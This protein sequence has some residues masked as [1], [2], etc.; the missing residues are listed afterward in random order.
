MSDSPQEAIDVAL[1]TLKRREAGEQLQDETV[2]AAHPHLSPYLERELKKLK[3][4]NVAR[5]AATA[6]HATDDVA[7]LRMTAFAAESSDI[8]TT[9][10]IHSTA[11]DE[12]EHGHA[13]ESIERTKL[14]RPSLRPAMAMLRVFHDDG[15]TYQSIPLRGE[16]TVIGRRTGDVLIEHDVLLSTQ[17]AEIVRTEID[18]VWHWHLRDLGSTNGSFVR[19]D[20]AR[21]NDGNDLLMGSN[22]YRFTTLDNEPRLEHVV[23]GEVVDSMPIDPSGTWIGREYR[24]QM[25][26]FWDELLDLKHAFIQVDRNGKW[27][28]K[29]MQSVNGVWLRVDQVRLTRSC[30]FQLGEQRFA[31]HG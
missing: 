24:S 31:F 26:C 27:S 15:H 17:H 13:P 10:A 25:E 29:N 8:H 4:L 18:R 2:I 1:Q 14:F 30:L 11:A 16:R 22:R 5:D 9:Q 7:D 6:A 3:L 19:I 28:I 21:I 20:G 12:L 23:G